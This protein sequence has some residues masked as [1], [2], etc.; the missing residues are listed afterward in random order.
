MNKLTEKQRKFV[1]YLLELGNQTEAYIRAGYKASSR[2]VAEANA[3]NLLGKES[4]K[5]YYEVKVKELEGDRVASSKEV[6]EYLTKV[7]REEEKEERVFIVDGRTVKVKC[8]PAI[9]DRN[10][11][12]EL[13]AKR[14]GLL[15][16]NVLL[17]HSVLIVDDILVDDIP[18][19]SKIKT[20]SD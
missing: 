1:H 11:A 9:K 16:E 4:I 2:E 6:M 7:I 18:G 5:E 14:Y 15:K 8:D 20:S 3:R 12:A 13:L 17:E 19:Y 10:R